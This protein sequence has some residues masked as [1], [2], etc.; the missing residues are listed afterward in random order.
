MIEL[1]RT[2]LVKYL[3]LGWRRLPKLEIIDRYLPY[4]AAHPDIR[5]RQKGKEFTLTK[6]RPL[7]L[8]DFSQQE[9]QT[10][11]LSAA[12]FA[13]FKKLPAKIVAKTRYYLPGRSQTI[14]LD[15][16]RGHLEGLVLADI[17]FASIKQLR[18]FQPPDFLL[19]DVTQSEIVA[20]GKLAGQNYRHLR[21]FLKKKHYR[22]IIY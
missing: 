16:F 10:I 22:R 12:E 9:E 13:A 18:R 19:A 8:K 20:G 21:A 5:L 11:R 15:V 6:K 4:S 7:N 17:E 2:F 1:E 3:P 14:E